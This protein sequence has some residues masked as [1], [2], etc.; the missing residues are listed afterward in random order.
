MKK[1]TAFAPATVANVAVGFDILGFALQGLGETAIVRRVELKKKGTPSVVIEK[2]P[3][4]PDISLDPLKNTATAGLVRLIHEKKLTCGF[5]V[6]LKKTIPIGSGLGGSSTSAVATMVAANALLDK[7]LPMHELLDYALTGEEVASGSRHADNVGPCLYGGLVHAGQPPHFKVSK[8]KTPPS[9]RC[10]I[11]LPA[12]RVRTEEARKMLSPQVDLKQMVQQ[13]S[14]LTGFILGCI[15][16][17]FDL[18][19]G[20]LR[21]VVI[22]P[23]RAKLIPGFFE[24]QK[25]AIDAGA[26][27][28]SISGSGPAMFALTDSQS[29]AQKVQ[30][31]LLTLAKEINLPL[32]G[33]WISKI[34]NRGAHVVTKS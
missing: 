27:G 8:I 1:A 14:N 25:A 22:E 16:Q 11:I 12:L 26:L 23:Q 10:I 6:Q 5:R 17:D 21:D 3:G 7:K 13:T 19:A 30:A 18:I 2:I 31:S 9:L 4:F 32:A 24:L 33:T 28:F 20:S 29:A 34:S 15:N